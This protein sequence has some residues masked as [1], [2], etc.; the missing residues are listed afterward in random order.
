MPVDYTYTGDGGVRIRGSG[1]VTGSEIVVVNGELYESSGNAAAIRYQVC[2]LTEVEEIVLTSAEIRELAR[3]DS[4][5]G[6][7]NPDMIIAVVASTDVVYGLARMWDSTV[8]EKAV[9]TRVFRET[10]AAHQWIEI[11]LLRRSNPETGARTREG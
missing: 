8:D 4:C 6:Q 7:L 2:D 3:Q 10:D 9:T 5:A 1:V 11:E